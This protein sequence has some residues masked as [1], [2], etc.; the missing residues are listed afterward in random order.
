M[1]HWFTIVPEL[2]LELNNHGVNYKGFYDDR[3]K[4]WY[5]P[6][7]WEKIRTW[8]KVNIPITD[9]ADFDIQTAAMLGGLATRATNPSSYSNPTL[10]PIG[11][12]QSGSLKLAL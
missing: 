2:K 10:K 1:F 4:G 8:V 3:T 12:L 11:V 7:N 5:T 6:P 9:N